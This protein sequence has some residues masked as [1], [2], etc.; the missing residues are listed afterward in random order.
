MNS[1]IKDTVISGESVQ[2]S[3]IQKRLNKIGEAAFLIA[4]VL[5][6]KEILRRE[7]H[8]GSLS[9]LAAV[10]K[11]FDP[12]SAKNLKLFFHGH[13]LY[14]DL[15]HR[16]QG[17]FHLVSLGKEAKMISSMNADVFISES[18]KILLEIQSLLSPSDATIGQAFFGSS[19]TIP[20]QS[21]QHVGSVQSTSNSPKQ[22]IKDIRDIKDI[23]KNRK[24][25]IV[26]F[27]KNKGQSS[28]ADIARALPEFSQKTV[29][30]ELNAMILEGT[31]KR[32]GDRRWSAYSIPE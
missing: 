11:A 3:Y 10:R 16:I 25:K 20:Q 24:E 28:I 17:L 12:E 2:L 14:Q 27:L 21:V 30:R 13:S 1:D 15:E 18:S 5:K 26:D 9:Y 22:V 6:D 31:I 29:Q 19:M 4:S 7:I 8:E 23:S 32:V